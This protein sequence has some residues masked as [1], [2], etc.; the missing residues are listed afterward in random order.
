[1]INFKAI[2]F[3]LWLSLGE[4]KNKTE[5][6]LCAKHMT[7]SA[8]STFQPLCS[9]SS[10]TR[11]R[12]QIWPLA[13]WNHTAELC[14]C[15]ELL[16]AVRTARYQ[17]TPKSP[18]NKVLRQAVLAGISQVGC[19][20]PLLH[21]MPVVFSQGFHPCNTSTCRY[22]PEDPAH[23]HLKAKQFPKKWLSKGEVFTRYSISRKGTETL[24][25]KGK[26]YY[27]KLASFSV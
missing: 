8:K 21:H 15:T 13:L 5:T 11:L 12:W 4:R 17:P 23:P 2:H 25:S 3:I 26:K 24:N 9:T 7:S 19:P 10:Q 20:Q 14:N 16:P 27:K 6:L 18:Q 1:M 22:L